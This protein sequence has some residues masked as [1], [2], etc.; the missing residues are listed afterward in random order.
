[1]SIDRRKFLSQTAALGGLVLSPFED[2]ISE[3]PAFRIP[4][5][6]TTKIMATNWGFSGSWDAFCGKAKQSGYDGIELWW[7]ND[8][9]QQKEIFA[10]LKKHQLSIGFLTAGSDRNPATHLEQFKKMIN[11]AAHQ[12]EQ[13]PLYINCH[14]GRDHFSFE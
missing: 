1:M 10:A 9:Q 3:K 11:A 7:Q 12:Q 6:F 5:N 8:P 2:L 4:P 13:R 14:S